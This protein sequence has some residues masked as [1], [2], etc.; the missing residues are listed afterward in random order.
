MAASMA[1]DPSGSRLASA[2]SPAIVVAFDA[3]QAEFI[4]ITRRAKGRFEHCD[5]RGAVEDAAERLDL[6]GRVI[7]R[8]EGEV[9]S[10]LGERV[11]D[12]NVWAAM[13]TVY[14]GLIGGR[15]NAELA[16]T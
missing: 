8:L 11:T 16:E 7:D 13:K 6:Y 3:Y 12:R 9:R 4:A 5:W 1:G 15:A 14:S 10:A 2:V